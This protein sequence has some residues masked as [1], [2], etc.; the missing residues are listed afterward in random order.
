MLSSR[1]AAYLRR[2]GWS[3]HSPCPLEKEL[4]PVHPRKV[5]YFLTTRPRQHIPADSSDILG[6]P[7]ITPLLAGGKGGKRIISP[8]L[9]NDSVDEEHEGA[10]D[11]RRAALSPSP[12]V[13]LSTHDLDAVMADDD[14]T[15]PPTPAASFSGRSSLARDGSNGGTPEGLSLVHNHRAASPPLEG[16]EK[17]FTQTASNMRIRGMSLDQHSIRPSLE[18]MNPRTETAVD[19]QMDETEEEKA[20]RNCEAAATLF[21]GHTDHIQ[22]NNSTIMSSPVMKA[23]PGP[24]MEKEIKVEEAADAAMEEPISILGDRGFGTAWNTRELENIG[25]DE[26]DDLLAAF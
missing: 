2:P 18:T 13:D 7:F 20:K 1:L 25:L 8:S 22:Y 15:T 14:F 4:V 12:E 21:G 23:V 16:D 10:E 26:L 9:S 6:T 19:V 3:K 24:S 11:R 5:Y 17:E